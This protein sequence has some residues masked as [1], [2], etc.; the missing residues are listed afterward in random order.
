MSPTIDA[1]SALSSS[2]VNSL[3]SLPEKLRLDLAE[4]L[5]DSVKQGFTSLE[6]GQSDRD[7]LQSRID[8]YD[9]GEMKAS[10]WRESL[11]RVEAR[12]GKEFPQDRPRPRRGGR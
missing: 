3:L 12:F 8:A 4:L 6:L 2:I 7:L 10:D 1:E 11:A 9:R 5:F